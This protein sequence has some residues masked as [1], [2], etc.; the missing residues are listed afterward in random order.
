MI[1][2]SMYII[3]PENQPYLNGKKPYPQSVMKGDEFRCS[4]IFLIPFL[5]ISIFLFSIS[6]NML[7]EQLLL[8]QSSVIAQ[9]WVTDREIDSDDDGNTYWITYSFYVGDTTYTGRKS[10]NEAVFNQ[11]P[12]QSP[13]EITYATEDPTVSRLNTD[14]QAEVDSFI[15]I[16]NGIWLVLVILGFFLL[17]K[18]YARYKQLKLAG[19]LVNGKIIHVNGW[20]DN[21]LETGYY[22]QLEVA[23]RT[24]DTAEIISG[25]RMYTGQHLKDKPLPTIGTPVY[26]F[27]ADKTNWEVL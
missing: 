20:H 25:K 6:F 13:I 16:F 11:Y 9:G 8:T 19:K 12:N 3:Y 22:I 15:I 23:L 21:E 14:N 26:I 17:I 2:P 4:I 10:V 27:Y 5:L 24:P 18:W 7:R 1:D